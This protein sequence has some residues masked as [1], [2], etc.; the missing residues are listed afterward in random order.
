MLE[1]NQV[2]TAEIT[3]VTA[4]GNG[5]CRVDGTVVF[6]PDTASGDI[7]EGK[8]VKVLKNYSFGIIQK[9]INPSADRITPECSEYKKC[10]GCIF[11]HISYEAECRIKSDMVLNAFQRIGGLSPEYDQFVGAE[12]TQRYRN[13]AQYPLAVSDGIAVCG[14]YA[15]RSH[16]VIPID[17]CPLQPQIFSDIVTI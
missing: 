12:N 8:I 6:V 16:R 14:F 11:Q 4:E 3:D 9:I 17:D 5:V 10:G 2:F 13:K 15:Q 7:I 1:K